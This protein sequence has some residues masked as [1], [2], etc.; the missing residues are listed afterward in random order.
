MIVHPI[1]H[2]F[3]NIISQLSLIMEQFKNIL[4]V[5][6]SGRNCGKT[7]VACNIIGQLKKEGHVIGLKITPHFHTTGNNQQIV[8]EGVDYK[9]FRETDASSQKDSSRMLQAG[10]SEVY[11]IQCTDIYLPE[12]YEHLKRLIPENYP[13]LCESGSFASVYQ[14]G[15]HILIESDNPYSSKKSYKSNLRKADLILSPNE[16]S[17][18]RLNFAVEYKEGHWLMTTK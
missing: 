4:L 8:K 5:S 12:I 16:F 1:N 7:T 18:T 13:V 15:Y 6:G 14:P 9:I 2:S 10:A 11:L 3:A 17:K